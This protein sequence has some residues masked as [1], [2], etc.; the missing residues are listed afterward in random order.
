M[1]ELA[2]PTNLRTEYHDDPIGI[3]ATAPRLSWRVSDG[4]RGARQ[5]AWQIRVASTPA[6]LA[7]GRGDLWDSGRVPDDS[8]HVVYEG[9]PLVARQRCRWQVRTWDAEGDPSPWSHS[10]RFE[11]GLLSLLDWGIGMSGPVPI[12][13]SVCGDEQ[14]SA[15][16]PYMRRTFEVDAPIQRA[17]LHITAFG[18][19]EAHLNGHRVTDDVLRPGWMD[20][21]R[22]VAYQTYDV[23]DLVAQGDNV[24]GAIL[25]DGWYCGFLGKRRQ[26][27]GD[28]P[29]L[30]ASLEIFV[31]G[32]DAPIVIGTDDH[33]RTTTG[34]ILSADNYM[35]ETYDARRELPGWASP[36]YDDSA[37]EPV[38]TRGN[39]FP[40]TTELEATI[41]PP[42]RPI[43]Q[44]RPTSVRERAPGIFQFDFG[45]NMVGWTR[46]RLQAEAGTEITLRFAEMLEADGTLHTENLRL[47]KATDVYV[48]RGADEPEVFEPRFTFHG[49]RYAEVSGVPGTL[50]EDD[51]IGIVIHSDAPMASSFECSNELVNQLQHNIEWSQRGNFLDVPTDCPQRN[52]RLGWTG[53][54][55]IFARTATYNMDV[56]AFLAKYVVDLRD[57]QL[58]AGPQRGQYPWVAPRIM[59][60]GGGPAWADAGIVIPWVLY[61]RYGDTR[62]LEEHYPSL[63]AWMDFLDRHAAGQTPSTWEGFGDWLSLDDDPIDVPGWDDRFGGTPRQYLWGAFHI[64]AADLMASIATIIERPGDADRFR[65]LAETLRSLFTETWM[66]DGRLT[67]TTQTAALLALHFELLRD[68]DTRR[69][70]ASDLVADVEGRGQLTTGFVG[71][72]YLLHVLRDVGRLDLA[73]QLLERTE[74]PG[75]LYPVTQGATTIWERWDS[76]TEDGGFKAHGMNSFNH[77]AYGAVGEWLFNTVAG[78]DTAGEEGAGYRRVVIAPQPGG[79]ITWAR[80]HVETIRGPVHTDWRLE[81]DGAFALDIG[82]PPNVTALVRIPDARPEQVAE[83]G[84]KLVDVDGVSNVRVED[85]S[86]LCDLVAGTYAFRVES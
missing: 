32:Q 33:W 53:D 42:V 4:R 23:T 34:P 22:R 59:A 25:G 54:I 44:L 52:E 51:L 82:I 60:L 67:V 70:V 6:A 21:G 8:T 73:Y 19:Y 31:S 16:A 65:R 36:G 38:I 66:H 24:L 83:N 50:S 61:E 69:Q 55:Q 2:A 41:A 10:A 13:A 29:Q 15:P 81:E 30:I 39:S 84:V 28:R 63:L 5:T 11:L 46:L 12:A 64:H 78:I 35:G 9:V 1:T 85:G 76:W 49:F 3:D 79:S 20:Y 27:W 7:D 14:T 77:Y 26:V 72:P 62:V 43:V 48:C 57:S 74:N 80:G 75:W 58:V 56:A 37:W 47:A 18:L 68:E 17:R 86:L 71:T 40:I 45:Q